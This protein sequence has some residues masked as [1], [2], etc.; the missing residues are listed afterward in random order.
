MVADTRNSLFWKISEYLFYAFFILFPFVNYGGFLYTGTSTRALNVIIFAAVLGIG[1]ALWLFKQGST[2]SLIKS[3]PLIALTLYLASLTISGIFGL[4]FSN[5]FW[6]LAT[7]M[8]GIWYFLSLGFFMLLLWALIADE[9]RHHAL[10]RVILFSTAAYSILDLFGS[11]GFGIIFPNSLYDAFTFGNSTFAAMYL[12]GAFMLSLYYLLQEERR[13]WWMYALPVALVINPNTLNRNVWYG[14]FSGGLAGEAQATSYVILFSLLALG[15]VWLVSKVKDAR[16][17]SKVSYA[18]LGIGLLAAVLTSFSLLSPGGYLREEYLSRA[19]AARPLVWEIS[20]RAIAERP[21]FGWGADNFERVFEKNYDNRLLEEQYGNEAWF[22]RAHNVFIDQMVDNGIIGLALYFAVYLITILVLIYTAL[23]AATKRD[24]IFAAILAVYFTLHIAELQTA[25][26]TSISYPMLAF[27]LVSAGVLYHRARA[28]KKENRVVP[29]NQ[30][31]RYAAGALVLGLFSWSLFAGAI[32]F[33]SAQIANGEI[34]QV[35]SAER[36]L[37]LYPTL[38]ASPVDVQALLWRIATDFQRGIAQDPSVLGDA[39]KMEGLMEEVAIFEETYRTY[40]ADNLENF[41]AHLNLADM[42]IYQMLF[43]VNKLEEAQEVLD[44][45]IELVPQSPQP[46]WMKAVAYVYMQKFALAR[47][48]AAQGLERNPQ[49][50][51][52]QDVVKYVENSIKT[53][54]EIDLFFFRQI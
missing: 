23:H 12:F 50:V 14:D 15:L 6:S 32:P 52:S 3:P 36:R 48:Y 19:T 28:L 22:D 53:F 4:S 1:F 44:R 34:R 25:F 54:P 30:T 7:R 2:V 47:E 33:T 27:L 41:R 51:Q 24:R 35:G 17:R 37:P 40:V 39:S 11:D 31:A 43:G 10:I 16:T 38:F 26:D 20:E 49:I 29:L 42:L 8:T 45:A 5:T 21:A 9:R 46:Y 13:K 18:L